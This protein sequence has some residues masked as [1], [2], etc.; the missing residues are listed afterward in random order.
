M[1]HPVFGESW[2]QLWPERVPLLTPYARTPRSS[3]G[4]LS[5]AQDLNLQVLMCCVGL[6][7]GGI[8]CVG[9]E[10]AVWKQRPR[11]GLVSLLPLHKAECDGHVQR[12]KLL[13][14]E[15]SPHGWQGG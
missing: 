7:S 3:L 14:F 2:P 10:D 6:G 4:A 5:H 15:S 8:R 13:S 12:A 9:V 11:A 1:W